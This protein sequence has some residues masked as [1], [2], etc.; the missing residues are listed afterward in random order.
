MQFTRDEPIRSRT[1]CLRA[2]SPLVVP[3]RIVTANKLGNAQ[4]EHGESAE[5][6]D[7]SVDEDDEISWVNEEE[8]EE[9]HIDDMCTCTCHSC[10]RS[11]CYSYGRKRAESVEL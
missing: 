9:D 7:E 10:R 5:G 2:E 8:S 3:A 1:K 4:S 6:V 11:I